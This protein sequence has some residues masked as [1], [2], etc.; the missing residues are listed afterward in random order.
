MMRI[1][2][3]SGAKEPKEPPKPLI[4]QGV[5]SIV[6]V[7]FLVILVKLIAFWRTSMKKQAGLELGDDEANLALPVM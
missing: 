3:K 4:S 1:P 5:G 6:T 7:T 2:T